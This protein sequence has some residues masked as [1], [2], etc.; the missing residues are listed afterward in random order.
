MYKV[1]YIEISFSATEGLLPYNNRDNY[2]N[3][4]LG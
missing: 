3:P 1:L 4:L 2:P